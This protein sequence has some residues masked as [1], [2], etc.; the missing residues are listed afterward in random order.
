MEAK[1]TV[2]TIMGGVNAML[3]GQGMIAR[4]HRRGLA[5]GAGRLRER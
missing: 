3:D 2:T 4:R 5:L 1:G